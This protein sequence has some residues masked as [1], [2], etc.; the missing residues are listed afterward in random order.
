MTKLS[1]QSFNRALKVLLSRPDS[2]VADGNA[3]SSY[4]FRR[5]LPTWADC[6]KLRTEER[7]ALGN[8][9]EA[10]RGVVQR[11]QEAL[12]YNTSMGLHYAG[13]RGDSAE[14]VKL[15]AVVSLRMAIA[16]LPP[17][18]PATWNALRSVV[19]DGKAVESRAARIW[20][21]SGELRLTALGQSENLSAV[22]VPVV[23]GQVVAEDVSRIASL[24][25]HGASS[26]SGSS[27]SSTSSSS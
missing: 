13:R 26:A 6:R 10:P 1:M 24:A 21:A 18:T 16:A 17:G 12:T 7:Q 27:S 19:P 15:E 20:Q 3:F 25:R 5:W 8:W 2:P 9:R 22:P 4:A 23:R 11:D 14:L